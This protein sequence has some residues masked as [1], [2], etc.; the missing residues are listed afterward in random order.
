MGSFDFA[1]MQAIQKELQ[2][3]YFDRWGGLGPEKGVQSLLWAVGEIGEVADI[4]KKQGGAIMT[5]PET[6]RHFVE[7][8]CDVMMYLN[9]LCLCYGVTPEEIETVYREKHRRNMQRW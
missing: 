8:F 1:A 4:L 6:R 9:D 5:D 7:E 3:K 2:A